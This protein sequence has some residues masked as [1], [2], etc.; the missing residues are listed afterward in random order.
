MAVPA[1]ELTPEDINRFTM[2]GRVD[3][4]AGVNPVDHKSSGLVHKSEK[5]KWAISETS[6][7]ECGV[8]GAVDA[9][10]YLALE[11]YSIRGQTVGVIGSAQQGF[12]PWYEA[13]VLS[14]GASPITVEYNPVVYEHPRMTAWTPDETARQVAAGFRFDALLCIS[15]IEHDGLTR[16]GDPLNPDSDLDAM[17]TFRSYLKGNGLLY[18]SCPVGRD[19]V[20]YNVHRIYGKARL[21][22]LLRDWLVI[23][24]FGFQDELLERDVNGGWKPMA[25]GQPMFR[26]YPAYEPVFVLRNIAPL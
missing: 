10:V 6:R 7:H 17:R 1:S 19:R 22:L 13:M 25:D 12:G 24:T 15:S 23:D 8:Y 16:Y 26:N 21:P 11:R 4:R 18:L 9:W 5:I 3:W 20:C 14:S 2:D